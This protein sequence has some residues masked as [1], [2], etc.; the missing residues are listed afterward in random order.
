MPPTLGEAITGQPWEG[1]RGECGRRHAVN[2]D[3]YDEE[4]VAGRADPRVAGRGDGDA[5]AAK[6]MRCAVLQRSH[7]GRVAGAVGWAA[8]VDGGVG[9]GE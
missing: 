3:V 2:I 1:L 8:V 4:L 7:E 6:L 9:D 5:E